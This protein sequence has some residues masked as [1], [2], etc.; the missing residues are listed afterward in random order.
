MKELDL[1]KFINNN[2]IEHQWEGYDRVMLLAWIPF[3]LLDEFAEI[4]GY[5]AFDEGGI[6]CHLQYEY[7][8]LDLVEVCDY[9]GIDPERICE[10]I[11]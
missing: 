9:F 7:V 5:G 1:Y 11:D 10:K 8:C 6:E 2:G 3:R 4:C